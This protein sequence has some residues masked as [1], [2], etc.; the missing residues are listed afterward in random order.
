M[1]WAINKEKWREVDRCG[2]N[3]GINKLVIRYILC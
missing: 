1:K 2:K 3:D